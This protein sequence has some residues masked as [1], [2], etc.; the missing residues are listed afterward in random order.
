MVTIP[1]V[2]FAVMRYQFLIFEGRSEAPE[3][4]LLTDIP[5]VASVGIWTLMLIW[6]L[7]GRIII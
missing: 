3:K 7:Y 4:I 5:L 1:I 6:I 2:I